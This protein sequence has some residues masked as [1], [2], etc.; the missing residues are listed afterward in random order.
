M[1][2]LNVVNTTFELYYLS[3]VGYLLSR[4][5]PSV[6]LGLLTGPKLVQKLNS[7]LASLYSDVQVVGFPTVSGRLHRDVARSLNFR[8]QLG[9]LNLQADVVCISS[10]REYFA[11]I[12][13]RNL[14][15][16]PRLV[17]L[18]MCDHECERLCRVREPRH[19][20]YLNL[21]NVLFGASTMRYRWHPDA[22]HA[23]QSKTYNRNP[24]HRTICISDWGHGQTRNE[25][26]LPPPFVALRGLYGLENSTDLKHE[27]AIL[28]AGERTP[29][30]KCWDATTQSLYDRFFDFIR[31]HFAGQRL[32]FKPRAR[33]TDT[34][35]LRLDGFEMV[36]AD[37]PFEELCLRNIYDRVIAIKSTACK[38]AAYCGQP[39]Y[40]LYRMF[41]LPM[42]IREPLDAYL[43]DMQRVIKIRDLNELLQEPPPAASFDMEKLSALYWQAVLGEELLEL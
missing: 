14:D 11:N 21:L 7:E 10:F 9:Q 42:S 25:Y 32:L 31:Q 4:A 20:A 29:P 2:V 1:R 23:F 3:S 43:A 35:Q 15:S 6:S 30:F 5:R 27:K 39:A 12:V 24:Y 18:R 37:T 8:R 40:V 36:P 34:A 17:A 22:A 16:G 26:R 38:V 41:D 13:C 33:L 19:A 28:V